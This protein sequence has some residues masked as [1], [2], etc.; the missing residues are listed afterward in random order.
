MADRDDDPRNNHSAARKSTRDTAPASSPRDIY[1]STD[2]SP[3]A[4][5]ADRGVASFEH[6]LA[7]GRLRATLPGRL[8][9]DASS[10]Y[11]DLGTMATESFPTFSYRST[12]YRLR[13]LQSLNPVDDLEEA[14]RDELSRR[15]EAQLGDFTTVPI[16]TKGLEVLLASASRH[17][18][19]P[20]WYDEE[21]SEATIFVKPADGLLLTIDFLA[22]RGE[23]AG[24]SAREMAP[25]VAKL[26]RPGSG[27][28]NLEAGVRRVPVT[29]DASVKLTLPE[30]VA[31]RCREVHDATIFDLL[32]PHHPD[33]KAPMVLSLWLFEPASNQP[34]DEVF[35]SYSDRRALRALGS[36][37]LFF[38]KQDQGQLHLATRVLTEAGDLLIE[39]RVDAAALTEATAILES[40][41][42]HGLGRRE[43]SERRIGPARR[44]PLVVLDARPPLNVRDG[45][46]RAAKIVG[47]L[48]NGQ[49]VEVSHH[50]EGWLHLSSPVDGWIWHRN[51]RRDCSLVE[52][53]D[54][55]V[56]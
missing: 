10:A 49:P 34:V 46:S 13:V 55:P 23:G 11:P 5:D 21:E 37:L 8:K 30:G 24:P 43:E 28:I 42:L 56:H 17:Y 15:A 22:T 9:H 39:G 1:P 41:R 18:P 38:T 16:K 27:R 6:E 32:R 54:A 2:A 52:D 19:C 36:D 48:D 29:P 50:R 14:A 51:T 25:R 4:V 7:Y 3:S 44:C 26:L 20:A 53:R 31:L 12:R 35:A 33:E 45:P 40:T 47:S